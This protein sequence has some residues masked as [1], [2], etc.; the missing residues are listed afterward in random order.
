MPALIQ[1]GV[2]SNYLIDSDLASFNNNICRLEFNR[3]PRADSLC[4]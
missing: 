1:G 4:I 2:V 3:E